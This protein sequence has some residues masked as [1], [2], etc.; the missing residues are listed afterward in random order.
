MD[1]FG[2]QEEQRARD[3]FYA[4]WIPDLFMQRV[5]DN[6]DWCLMCPNECPGLSDSWGK[7]WFLKFCILI[8][9]LSLP[10]FL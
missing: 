7:D 1:S 9:W 4:M 5:E 8:L 6:G 2:F 3:L 10:Y